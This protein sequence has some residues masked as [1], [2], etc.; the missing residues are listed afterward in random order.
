MHAETW[1]NADIAITTA[2]G[3]TVVLSASAVLQTAYASYD[4]R[5]RLAGQG[6]DVH[7]EAVQ[8]VVSQDT[9]ITV[10]GD[11]SDTELADVH[12]LLEKLG[13]MAADFLAGDLD[14]AVTHALDLGELDTLANF[15]ASFEYVQ[16]V[17]VEQ[18][19]TA[20]ENLRHTPASIEKPVSSARIHSKSIECLL[21]SMIQVTEASKMNPET[22]AEALPQFTDRLMHILIKE[23]GADAPKT[24][25]AEQALTK[26]AAHVY[27]MVAASESA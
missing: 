7:A 8:L 27:N 14:D 1:T 2:E 10:A 22:L 23:Y 15:D 16:H 9:A 3:D 13:A 17:R 25:L 26:F 18:Q 24:Q 4:A 21:D 11:L 6:F 20:Q 5:G 12:H 19:Y